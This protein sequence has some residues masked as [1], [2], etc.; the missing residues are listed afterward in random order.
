MILFTESV[1][2][3]FVVF[4]IRIKISMSVYIYFALRRV[5]SIAVSLS[6]CLRVSLKPHI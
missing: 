3:C 2:K 4:F 1:C 6:V 5:Q